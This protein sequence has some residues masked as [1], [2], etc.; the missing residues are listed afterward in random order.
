VVAALGVT[1]DLIEGIDELGDGDLRLLP[2]VVGEEE[3]RVADLRA[4]AGDW[5]RRRGRVL[6]R[7]GPSRGEDEDEDED[8]EDAEQAGTWT[9][10]HGGNPSSRVGYIE[11]EPL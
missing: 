1:L 2:P 6:R 4:R 3:D 5:A 7:R 10:H 11:A 8:D 9:S